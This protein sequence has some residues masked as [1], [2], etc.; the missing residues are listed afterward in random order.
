MK[1]TASP[2]HYTIVYNDL[3]EESQ[4]TKDSAPYLEFKRD[5]QILAF[6]LCFLYY[7]WTGAIK[8][9]SAV[10]YAHTLSNFIGDRYNPRKGDDT[11]IQAHP[12][13]DKNRSLYFI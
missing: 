6:K 7:N 11:L 10:R 9:P 5:V 13:Y 4:Q 1:G 3:I 12:R 2:T 8:T